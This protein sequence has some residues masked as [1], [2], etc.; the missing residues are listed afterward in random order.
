MT[1]LSDDL[2]AL[3][4][5]RYRWLRDKAHSLES[6]HGAGKS[7]YH[8]IGGVRELKSGDDLDAAVDAAIAE[9]AKNAETI[10]TLM[11]FYAVTNVEDLVLSQ[12]RHIEK[13]QAQLP[14]I[15]HFTP[16]KVREG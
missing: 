10:K 13:L 1:S 11:A 6:Q 9:A 2:V 12:S 7:C 15:A 4:A 14:N 3:D 5:A 16:A 8:A